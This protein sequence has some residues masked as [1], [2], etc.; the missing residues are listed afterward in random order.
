LSSAPWYSPAT[1][2]ASG[3]QLANAVAFLTTSTLAPGV[4]RGDQAGRKRELDAVDE[5]ETAQCEGRGAD[6]LQFD[7]LEIAGLVGAGRVRRGGGV[8]QLGDSDRRC[9][10][11][12]LWFPLSPTHPTDSEAFT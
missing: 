3:Y 7:V 2:R 1:L 12:W 4:K 8:H 6:V 9:I 10:H 11:Q 5:L